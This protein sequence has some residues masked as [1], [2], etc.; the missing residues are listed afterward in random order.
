MNLL[1]DL[2][3]VATWTG[4]RGVVLFVRHAEREDVASHE[5]PRHDAPLTHSGVLSARRLG[6]SMAGRVGAIL[7]SPVLRCVQTA[8]QIADRAGHAVKIV[9]DD[10]LGDPGSLVTDAE[11][12]MTSLV[13]L[14]FHEAARQIGLGSTLPG[15]E[16]PDRAAAVLLEMAGSLL[17]G[18]SSAA[19]LLITHDLI[20][21]S[22]VARIIRRPLSLEEWP[23][24]LHGVAIWRE[25]DG[26]RM[27]YRS[28]PT[29]VPHRLWS[30]VRRL[31][32]RP[33]REPTPTG[34]TT[35]D[36]GGRCS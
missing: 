29:D 26:L 3:G 35:R 7:S 1:E 25:H 21:A 36:L 24:Y 27:L 5:F 2:D 4:S 8:Q 14:G 33:A 32:S 31:E 12:A 15:F 22:F 6:E 19:H 13:T 17:G 28:V 18:G 23:G 10:R 9:A 16:E 20:L 30:P 11:V 34:P